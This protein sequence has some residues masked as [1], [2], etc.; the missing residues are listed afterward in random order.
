[1]N[2]K[3][4][5][6]FFLLFLIQITFGQITSELNR[7]KIS[8]QSE[9]NFSLNEKRGIKSHNGIIYYVEKDLQTLTAYKDGKVKWELNIVDSCGKPKVGKPEIRFIEL[10]NHEIHLT[11]GKH[12]FAKVN[13]SN[14]KLNCMGAD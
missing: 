6:T 3:Y 8:T 7:S 4:K 14:G 1:M 11:F 10:N 9:L 2:E 13:I 12:S 5:Y